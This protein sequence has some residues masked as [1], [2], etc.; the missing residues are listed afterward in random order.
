MFYETKDQKSKQTWLENVQK[1]PNRN[2]QEEQQMLN[3][4]TQVKLIKVEGNIKTGSKAKP[5]TERE[6]YKIK[7]NIEDLLKN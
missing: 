5:G 6:K 3:S 1:S 2:V 7:V 4:R